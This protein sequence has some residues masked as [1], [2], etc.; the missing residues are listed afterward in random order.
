M[1]GYI[2]ESVRAHHTCDPQMVSRRVKL[3]DDSVR[4]WSMAGGKPDT[5]HSS[6]LDPWI[7]TRIDLNGT[8]TTCSPEGTVS[9]LEKVSPLPE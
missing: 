8:C 3:N 9:D 7:K 4:A 2:F 6:V 5:P 1:R